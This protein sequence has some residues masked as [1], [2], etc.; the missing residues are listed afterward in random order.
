[1]LYFLS[2]NLK[3]NS[4]ESTI[5]TSSFNDLILNPEYDVK[6]EK[7]E[8]N[9]YKKLYT[10]IIILSYVI[11][12]TVCFIIFLYSASKHTNLC[13]YEEYLTYIINGVIIITIIGL[14]V[15]MTL[16]GINQEESILK[17]VDIKKSEAM[18]S[19]SLSSNQLTIIVFLVMYNIFL[20]KIFNDS[21]LKS[22]IEKISSYFNF[23]PIL[24]QICIKLL[25]NNVPV[26][27]PF[28]KKSSSNNSNVY[29]VTDFEYNPLSSEVWY[30]IVGCIIYLIT[31][32]LYYKIIIKDMKNTNNSNLLMFFIVFIL[33]IS[34]ILFINNSKVIQESYFN[35]SL[36]SYTYAII[37][38]SFLFC[39]GTIL[40][41]FLSYDE[42]VK[43]TFKHLLTYSLFIL[44]GIFF[45]FSL[46]SWIIQL[47]KSF[48]T[49]TTSVIGVTLNIAIIIT[50][51]AILFKMISYSDYYKESPLLQ[52][53]IGSVFYIPCFLI[54]CVNKLT[55]YYKENKS[56]IQ[57][58]NINLTDIV[59]LIIIIILY[60]LYYYLPNIYTKYSSQGGKLLIQEPIYLNNKKILIND[61]STEKSLHTY[62]YGLSCWVFIDGGSSVNSANDKLCSILN[63][64]NKPNL[65]YKGKNNTFVITYDNK[66]KKENIDNK[67]K[68]DEFGNIIIYETND[69]LLQKW[70]NIIF[71]YSSG[72]ID[73]FING[74]LKQSYEGN[75]PYMKND[76][77]VSGQEDG[78]NG[79]ICNVVYYNNALTMEK[80]SNI[81]NSVKMLN[82]PILLNYYD[83]LYLSSLKVENITEKIGLTQ[84]K[85]I[86]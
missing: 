26:P 82:P 29:C 45:L 11:I 5:Q 22:I 47:C 54:S 56:S 30:S 77:I 37:A 23:K 31:F 35:N 67:Y 3:F 80:I 6:Q 57:D 4:I 39:I 38:Y 33:F 79:G 83:S 34:I 20:S 71:N 65:K 8:L 53:I 78:I 63:Y 68:L 59:L 46:I 50:I 76:N 84:L 74:D 1:L 41:Y 14:S 62:S 55:G 27:F 49:N 73:I 85:K 70:N 52:V 19:L 24:D 64:G 58:I 28:I 66:N 43:T 15:N 75:I 36:T 81:Y 48:T 7:K 17:G 21:C 42:K 18:S 16:S 51:M 25:S 2:D 86:E 9:M 10:N 60:L 69:L 40:L 72:I 12:I 44:F 32:A 13:S 61:S